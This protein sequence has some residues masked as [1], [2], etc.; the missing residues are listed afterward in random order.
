MSRLTSYTRVGLTFDVTDTGPLDGDPVVLLHGF[1][2]RATSWEG[3]SARLHEHGLRTYAPD[4]RGY[5]P[6]ARPRFR[7]SYRLTEL[8]ADVLELCDRIGRPVH[9]VGHDWG[10]VVAWAVAAH[11]PGR[12]R[13]LVAVSVPHPGAFLEAMLHGPQLKDSWYFLPFNVTGLV[14][15]LAGHRVET[16]ET[17][18]RKGGMTEEQLVRFRREIVED[19]ALRGGLGWYRALPFGSPGYGRRRVRVPTTHV[20]STRDVALSREGAEACERWVDAPY[21]LVV[22]EGMNHWIP[23]QAPGPLADAILARTASGG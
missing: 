6:G 11:H 23:A 5:S 4:Q 15:W 16:L 12:V 13:S 14:E 20:W 21:E 8:V 9:L 10:A 22:L 17:W 2:E 7:W 3:V 1:P 18:L 19:G